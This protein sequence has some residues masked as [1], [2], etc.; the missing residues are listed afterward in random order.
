MLIENLQ[1]FYE[2]DLEGKKLEVFRK[3]H[4]VSNSLLL[5]NQNAKI[6]ISCVTKLYIYGT[7]PSIDYSSCFNGLIIPTYSQLKGN[8]RIHLK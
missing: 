7:L 6:A 5:S 8:S 4:W 3:F 2:L 1:S